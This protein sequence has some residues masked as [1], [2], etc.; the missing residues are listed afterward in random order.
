MY[1]TST[2]TDMEARFF[3]LFFFFL[4]YLEADLIMHP[5]RKRMLT[6]EILNISKYIRKYT[7]KLAYFVTIKNFNNFNN[8]Y[9]NVTC[10]VRRP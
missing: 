9:F 7:N 3:L 5:R 6:Q 1:N 10:I 2:M 4:F 8:I